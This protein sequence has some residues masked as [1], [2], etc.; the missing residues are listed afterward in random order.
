MVTRKHSL[1]RNALPALFQN[2]GLLSDIPQAPDYLFIP[3]HKCEDCIWNS[4]LLAEVL[5][6]PLGSAKIMSWNPGEEMVDGLELETP[7]EEI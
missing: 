2:P 7:V 3:I 6:Q 4:H 1:T 5:D